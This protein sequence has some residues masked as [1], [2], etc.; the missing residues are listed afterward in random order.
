MSP[1]LALQFLPT[2]PIELDTIF[3]GLDV[4]ELPREDDGAGGELVRIAPG[5]D[6]HLRLRRQIQVHD[7]YAV[8]IP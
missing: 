8:V 7:Y 1:T 5:D 2:D 4:F 6:A 3:D